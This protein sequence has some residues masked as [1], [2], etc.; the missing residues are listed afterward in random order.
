[1]RTTNPEY[2][3]MAVEPAGEYLERLAK[4]GRDTDIV[5]RLRRQQP[6]RRA[7]SQSWM[8]HVAEILVYKL[9]FERCKTGPQFDWSAVRLVSLEV[10]MD[11]IHGA[12][13]PSGRKQFINDLSRE[14][15]FKG[16]DECEC[17]KAYEHLKRLRIPMIDETRI[18]PNTKYLESVAYEVGLTGAETRPTPGE[19]LSDFP[20]H[21]LDD[22]W[23]L[24]GIDSCAS[25]I[26]RD[27]TGCQCVRGTGLHWILFVSSH[28]HVAL[29][30]DDLF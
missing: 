29:H 9:G 16:G 21:L 28:F 24:M 10:H 5:W 12:G 22:Y 15:E 26:A 17:G 6:E 3:E 1:M 11:E 27:V 30:L 25:A 2:E 14:I 4:A 13:T 20:M 18:H 19:R 7:A 23:V 8:E